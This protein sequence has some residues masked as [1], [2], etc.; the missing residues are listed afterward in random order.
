MD[1][2][3]VSMRENLNNWVR[4]GY[5]DNL[6]S[7]FL[8]RTMDYLTIQSQTLSA[9]IPGPATRPSEWST[10][11]G[12]VLMASLGVIQARCLVE[13]ISVFSNFGQDTQLLMVINHRNSTTLQLTFT[14]PGESGK[15]MEEAGGSGAV[16][17]SD[18]ITKDREIADK[19][20]QHKYGVRSMNKY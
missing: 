15:P 4:S 16:D 1:E 9:P 18:N 17:P 19:S 13:A 5:R 11:T 2:Q 12:D 3:L 7:E 8:I 10:E 6:L 14:L 20:W